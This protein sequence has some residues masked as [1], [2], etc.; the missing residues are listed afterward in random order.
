MFSKPVGREPPLPVNDEPEGSPHT[1]SLADI[2]HVSA[3]APK[4]EEVSCWESGLRMEE[5][6]RSEAFT[7]GAEQGRAPRPESRVVGLARVAGKRGSGHV[8]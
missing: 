3:D 2:S 4:L 1:A 6:S 7:S 5:R 8:P